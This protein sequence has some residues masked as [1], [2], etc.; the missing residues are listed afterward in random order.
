MLQEDYLFVFQSS[1]SKLAEVIIRENPDLTAFLNLDLGVWVD[2]KVL[3][4][5]LAPVGEEVK[6]LYVIIARVLIGNHTKLNES[7]KTGVPFK[8]KDRAGEEVLVVKQPKRVY[9][10]Y[11][12]RF[13]LSK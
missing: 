9:P 13:D 12:V 7:P 8:T 5:Q 10:S 1:E 2:T 3:R 6:E 4:K 11:L